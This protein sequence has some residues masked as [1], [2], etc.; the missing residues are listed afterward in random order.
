MLRVDTLLPAAETG[1][2]TLFFEL[3]ENM[4]H[5][6]PQEPRRPIGCGATTGDG[7][8]DAKDSGSVIIK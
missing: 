6:T 2:F 3:A 7:A 1:L 4:V 5:Q 8:A